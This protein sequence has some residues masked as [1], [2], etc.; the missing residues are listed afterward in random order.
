MRIL[1]VSCLLPYPTV[2]H[3]GGTDLFHLLETLNQRGH[4]VHLVSLVQPAE[5]PYIAALRPTVASLQTIEPALT[6]RQKLHHALREPPWRWG[7]RARAEVRAAIRRVVAAGIDVA[8]FEWT[9][10]A[11]FVDAV[12]DRDVVTVLDEVDVSFR[13]LARAMG[14][15]GYRHRRV[16]AARAQEL[17]WC[18]RFDAILTRSVADQAALEPY[19]PGQRLHVF[20]P[21]THVEELREI[22]PETR[23]PGTVLFCGAMDRAE[24]ADAVLWFY[25]YCWPQV[26]A[27]VPTAR[28]LIV[29]HAPRPAVVRLAADPTVTV[30]GYI[31]DLRPAY[32]RAEV[33]IAP[34]LVGGG[35]LNKVI[36]GMAAGRP[37]VTTSAGNEGVAAPPEAVYVADEPAAFAAAV[38]RL[39]QD[40]AEWIRVATHGRTF[41]QSTYRWAENV[42]R[43]ENL[44][45]VIRSTRS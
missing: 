35:V 28:L 3:G 9:E 2:P 27:A 23:E 32:A 16:Q 11:R 4:E 12:A 26:R 33:C 45:D 36:D 38:I 19:L 14:P 5:R 8:Q 44:Y 6:W 18:R 39:L 34:S 40:P 42:T 21:W 37:V 24:N 41:V 13:P 31:P 29:G 15:A 1:F 10:T 17:A 25:R 22:S 7:R 20:Q 43:L 30:T